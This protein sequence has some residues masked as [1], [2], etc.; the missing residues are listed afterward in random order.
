MGAAVHCNVSAVCLCPAMLRVGVFFL[1]LPLLR[2]LFSSVL[3]VPTRCLPDPRH[4]SPFFT[5]D[6]AFIPA[7]PASSLTSFFTDPLS[8]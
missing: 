1:L 6:L 4:P 8:R 3:N 5:R 2:R 7:H